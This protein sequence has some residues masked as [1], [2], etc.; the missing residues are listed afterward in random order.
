MKVTTNVVRIARKAGGVGLGFRF[1]FPVNIWDGKCKDNPNGT[2][3][4]GKAVTVG[5]DLVAWCV[6]IHIYYG[7]K[8]L[9]EE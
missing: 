9:A 3:T 1:H 5:L 7:I 2:D 6:S 4:S 8:P